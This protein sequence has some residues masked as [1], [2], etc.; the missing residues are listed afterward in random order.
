VPPAADAERRVNREGSVVVIGNFDGVHL[1][2]Q[3]VVRAALD[4]ATAK[5]LE[6]IALTFHPHPQEVLG[7]APRPAL[8]R[9]ERK[10]TLLART[11]VDVVVERFTHELSLLSPGEFVESILVRKLGAKVVLVGENFRFGRARAGDF[12]ELVRLG[13]RSGFGARAVSLAAD[14]EGLF[15]SSRVRA[16][17]ASGELAA[18]ERCLGRPHSASGLVA[19]GVQRGRTI[20][21]PTANLAEVEEVLPPHGVYAC[22]VDR[23]NEDAEA[24]SLALAV[25]NVGVR[26]TVAAGFSIE[27]HLL[28][29]EADLYGARLRVHF[30]SRL[31][32]ERKF[33]SLAALTEQIRADVESARQ[34][35]S[36][37]VPREKGGAWA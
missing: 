8:T 2:H 20:G 19:L 24:K 31:R 3:A 15:S 25:V 10:L 37:R 33:P 35:L 18:A 1:G 22:L 27:A 12:D 26:P 7:R 21:V 30:V 32:E 11:G 14:S 29:F 17:L 34:E 4:E 23:E 9:I 16:A 6:P 36:G 28:D 13:E 5:G